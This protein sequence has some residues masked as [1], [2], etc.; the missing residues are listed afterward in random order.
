M[1]Y[2]NLQFYHREYLNSAS[3]EDGFCETRMWKTSACI[4]GSTGETR[5]NL[6]V[7]VSYMLQESAQRSDYFLV[8]QANF[9]ATYT[10]F[11]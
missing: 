2:H 7:S 6:R 5:Y 11:F 8:Q 1:T 4:V 10:G 3:Q 9:T